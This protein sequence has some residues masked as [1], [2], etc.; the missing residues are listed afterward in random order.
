MNVQSS[1]PVSV[2]ETKLSL[3]DIFGET[4]FF[5]QF[6]KANRDT[7]FRV[8][9]KIS[10]NAN[11]LYFE[12]FGHS[13]SHFHSFQGLAISI[14]KENLLHL[15]QKQMVSEIWNNS[16]IYGAN[17]VNELLINDTRSLCDFNEKIGSDFLWNLTLYG[18]DVKI[19]ILDT[20]LNVSNPALNQTMTHQSRIVGKW[21]FLQ[22]NEDVLDDNGHGTE[23]AGIIGSNGLFGYMYGVAPNCKFLI[24]KI[25]DYNSVGTVETL[26]Q[27]IDWAIENGAD[28]INLSLGKVV[29]NLTSPEVEAVNFAVERGVLVCVSAGNARGIEEFGYNNLHTILSPGISSKAITVGAIDN[30]NVLYEYSSAGPV[31]IN[32]DS[33]T[34]DYL[35]DS[36][37]KTTTWLKPDVVAPGVLLNTTSAN[38][39]NLNVVS[40]TSY[41]TAVVSGLCLLL[42]QQYYDADPSLVKASLIKTCNPISL[43]VVSPFLKNISIP[44]APYFQGSG[45]VDSSGAFSYINTHGDFTLTSSIIPYLDNYYFK[46]SETCFNIQLY[47]HKTPDNFELTISENLANIL[48]V[49]P[50][51]TSLAV[52]QY[53]LMITINTEQALTGFHQGSLMFESIDSTQT[54]NVAFNVKKA[55]GR[56]LIDYREE[57]SDIRYSL[58]GN[59]YNIISISK[60]YGLIPIINSQDTHYSTFNT[61]N[62]NEFEVIA[63]VNSKNTLLNPISSADIAALSDYINPDGAYSGG[64][65]IVLPSRNSDL[66][67]INEILSEVNVFYYQDFSEN[68]SLDVS[69][70]FNVLL[71]DPYFLNDLYLPYPV[72]LNVTNPDYNSYSDKLVYGNQHYSNGSLLVG[73]NTLDMF[74]DSPYLYSPYESEYSEVFMSAYY[75]D[76]YQ[77]LENMISS[78]VVRS[79]TFS[80]SLKSSEISIKDN[81]IL[82]I[83]TANTFKVMPNWEFYMTISNEYG[84]YVKENTFESYD[85]GTTVFNMKIEDMDILSGSY[86]LKIHSVSGTKSWEIKILA[87]VSLGPIIISITLVLCSVFLIMFRKKTKK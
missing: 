36:I 19:A 34:S 83:N 33:E 1:N 20:G 76:N 50:L 73:G 78:T 75:G 10:S 41:A 14:S 32:F 39:K 60:K 70:S 84:T 37:P 85:N 26:I 61:M 6:T 53:D 51:P 28:V 48:Y 8:I 86:T 27:G 56:I 45:L 71:S 52:G 38:G 22:R 65:L 11:E 72:L 55:Y 80:Y 31:A 57:G 17:S 67:I 68:V 5:K 25:L 81:I 63:L 23:V 43:N 13:V 74:L 66:T 21:N 46:N 9:V 79:L 2:K 87:S 64:A 69:S 15:V 42:I 3:N 24:G 62:L 35:Y 47:I 77:L 12:K 29:S 44:I 30:N 58:N 7:V 82:T 49:S 16:L 40:G 18:D 4:K 54:I 59:L